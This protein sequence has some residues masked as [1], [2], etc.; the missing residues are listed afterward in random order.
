M[1]RVAATQ[2]LRPELVK[3]MCGEPATWESIAATLQ[4]G[5]ASIR[6]RQTIRDVRCCSGGS[7]DD[8]LDPTFWKRG[9]DRTARFRQE[10][11]PGVGVGGCGQLLEPVLVDV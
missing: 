7:A 10:R 3:G 6:L 4:L 2:S 9:G 5:S 11:E 1:C 8:L